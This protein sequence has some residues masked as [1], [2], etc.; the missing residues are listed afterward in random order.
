MT[1]TAPSTAITSRPAAA[2]HLTRVCF[3]LGPPRLV[4]AELEWFTRTT[5]PHDHS[6][7]PAQLAA[8]RAQLDLAIELDQPIVVHSRDAES[9][10][11]PELDRYSKGMKPG[12]P[13]G[14]IHCFTG[15][16]EFGRAC[17]DLGFYVSFSGILTFKN[18][19]SLR[20]A[21]KD[22]P[23]DRILVETDSPY[24]APIP[25]RGKKGEPS[26]VLQTAMKLAEVKGIPLEEV[27]RATTENSRRLFRL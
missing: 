8:L 17:L 5:D 26:M 16:R 27:A 21:A 3:K 7:R 13:V 10:L 20:E 18:A 25:F 22:F 1:T 2:A 23:L 4:G 11:L 15:T 24:L 12:L 14:V 9:D 19:E 6:G